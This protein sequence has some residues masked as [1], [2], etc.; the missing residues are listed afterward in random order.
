MGLPIVFH[1]AYVARDVPAR[2]RFPMGKFRAVAEALVAQGLVRDLSGFH[3]PEPAPARWLELA[4]TPGYVEQVLGCRVEPT[5]ERRIGFK[6]TEPVARRSRCAVA[7]TLLAARLA[8]ETGAAANTAGGSHHA[9]PDGGAG[10]CVF[11]DVGVA[12]KLMLTEGVISRALVIDLDVHQGDGTARIFETDRRVF[13]LSVHCETNWPRR[14]A[15][16][17]LDLGLDAGVDDDAYLAAARAAIEDALEASRPDIVFYNAG[18]DVHREDR[19]GLLDI[20]DEGLARRER[21]VCDAVMRRGLPIVGVLGGG[22][23]HDLDALA[24]RHTMMHAAL[25]EG[26]RRFA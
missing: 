22:Y 15:I 12:A 8:L 20:T 9:M 18:V 2:H 25:A 3:R 14:K 19:L 17:D 5:L 21:M 23:T 11:N 26:L 7:G 1:E 24:R 16:S 10:F 4:H 6:M 13:T